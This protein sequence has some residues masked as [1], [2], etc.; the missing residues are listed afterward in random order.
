MSAV[1]FGKNTPIRTIGRDKLY[2]HKNMEQFLKILNGI[3]WRSTF[4]KEIQKLNSNEIKIYWYGCEIK[5]IEK[6]IDVIWY[7]LY[8][9][10]ITLQRIYYS[11]FSDGATQ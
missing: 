3:N 8:I 1:F 2:W 7:F 9:D 11:D 10:N 5:M 4:L 6:E